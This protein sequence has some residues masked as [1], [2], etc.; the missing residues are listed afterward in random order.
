MLEER[1]YSE[2]E[3]PVNFREPPSYDDSYSDQILDP[4]KHVSIWIAKTIS[5]F[6]LVWV[7]F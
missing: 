2:G 1:A 4:L 6:F 7:I 5:F 3:L